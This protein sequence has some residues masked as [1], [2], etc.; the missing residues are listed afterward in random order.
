MSELLACCSARFAELQELLGSAGS[1]STEM[2]GS[3]GQ[4]RIGE[5]VLE[6]LPLKL[7]DSPASFR[8]A[9]GSF[10]PRPLL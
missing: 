10:L 7:L 9:L 4:A 1:F 2:K 8:Q 6:I 5:S 3:I